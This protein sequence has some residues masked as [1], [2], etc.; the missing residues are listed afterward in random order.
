MKNT[1]RSILCLSVLS[2]LILTGCNKSGKDLA[3]AGWDDGVVWTSAGET[4]YNKLSDLKRGSTYRAYEFIQHSSYNATIRRSN[5]YQS[6]RW[7][8]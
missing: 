3:P 7:L 2:A 1:K 8:S 6:C 4:E 5:H